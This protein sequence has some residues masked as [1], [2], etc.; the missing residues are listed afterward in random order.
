MKKESILVVDDDTDI[1]TVVAKALERPGRRVEVAEDARD[2][3]DLARTQQFDVVVSD[4]KMEKATSGLDLLKAF[5]EA[6]PGT[7]VVLMSAF[8]SLDTAVEAVRAGAFDYVAKPFDVREVMATV[9]RALAGGAGR[10]LKAPSS[11]DP[12]RFVLELKDARTRN[13]GITEDTHAP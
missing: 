12:H 2:A 8:S 13:A 6:S 4:M 1:R 10:I 3:L 9:E 5:K 7:R 11:A